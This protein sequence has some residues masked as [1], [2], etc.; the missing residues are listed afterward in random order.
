MSIT[1]DSE[2]LRAATLQ[3]IMAQLDESARNKLLADAIDKSMRG[4]TGYGNNRVP[5][6]IEQAFQG[7]VRVIAD[8]EIKKALAEDPS[9]AARIREVIAKSVAALLDDETIARK[10]G[11]SFARSIA[12]GKWS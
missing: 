11:E 6:D 4:S 1:I 3:V 8:Q 9:V 12:D 2:V 5:S 10:L 7:A